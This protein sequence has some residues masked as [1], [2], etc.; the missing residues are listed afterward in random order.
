MTIGN[1]AAA[2]HHGLSVLSVLRHAPALCAT[3]IV[4]RSFAHLHSATAASSHPGVLLL[5]RD[6]DPLY[7]NPAALAILAYPDGPERTLGVIRSQV[8]RAL[9]GDHLPGPGD[10]IE[11]LSGRRRYIGKFFELA[12]ENGVV[13]PGTVTALILERRPSNPTD[14]SE[15]SRLYRL[16]P[17]ESETVKYL[18]LGL[19]TKE[20][21]QSMRVSPNTIKQFVRIAMTKMGVSTRSGIVAKVWGGRARA[22]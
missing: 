14:V 13:A 3:S 15:V 16:S 18:M 12:S 7:F 6:L 20:V 11:F 2:I 5:T 4:T 19:T 10:Q 8:R 21:A 17:R 9:Q 1:A 22:S